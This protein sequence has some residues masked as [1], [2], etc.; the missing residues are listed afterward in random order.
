MTV[1]AAGADLDRRA[2]AR[3]AAIGAA[4]RLNGLAAGAKQVVDEREEPLGQ[5]DTTRHRVVEVEGRPAGE[6]CLDLGEHA[7]VP[8]V[9]HEEE[10][11]RRAGEPREA[12]EGAVERIAVVSIHELGG[13]DEPGGRRVHLLLGDA[14]R[15]P[16]DVLVGVVLE[17]LEHG[18][19]P[20]DH[21][22]AALPLPAGGSSPVSKTSST[23]SVMPRSASV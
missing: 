16:A 17:L 15:A 7:Q 3:R 10:R 1:A 2:D 6:G 9:A 11:A 23:L 20:G 13:R 4:A 22:L 14:D 21:H 5:P 8:W 18:H 19:L 12:D